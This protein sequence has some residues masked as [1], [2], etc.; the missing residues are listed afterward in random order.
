MSLVFLFDYI[1]YINMVIWEIMAA[2]IGG[3]RMLATRTRLSGESHKHLSQG[4]G[5][6][7]VGHVGGEPVCQRMQ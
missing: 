2:R 7:D 6:P 1:V 4:T 3:E 5:R